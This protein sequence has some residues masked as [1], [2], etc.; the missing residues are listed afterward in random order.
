MVFFLLFFFLMI[1]RPPIATVTYTLCPYTTLFRSVVRRH[2]CDTRRLHATGGSDR[3]RCA[4]AA[5]SRSRADVDRTLWRSGDAEPPV[6]D[7]FPIRRRPDSESGQSGAGF[8]LR[9]LLF[10]AG[11]SGNGVADADRKSK[12]L[13]SSH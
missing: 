7:R 11:L 12:R 5:P 4:V 8:Q 9:T 3:V 2:R 1:R 13:N 10:R 6:D